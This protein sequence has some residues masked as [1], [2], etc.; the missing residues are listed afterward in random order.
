MIRQLE[1]SSPGLVKTKRALFFL[2]A[3]QLTNARLEAYAEHC[4][5]IVKPNTLRLFG[6]KGAKPY[7]NDPSG[8]S[9]RLVKNE[10]DQWNDTIGVWGTEVE[11]FLG[12]T[13]PGLKYTEEPMNANGAAHL[14]AIE[15]AHKSWTFV[16]GLH[17]QQ[18]PCLDQGVPFTVRRDKDRDGDAEP[19][20]P[21]DTGWFAIQIHAG[22]MGDKVGAWSAACQ[23]LWGGRGPGSPWDKFWSIIEASGQAS[24]EY[25][26]MDASKLAEFLKV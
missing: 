7:G 6:L 15:E 12:T 8:L 17:H 9:V 10:L 25:F 21:I 2:M 26:L 18:Y 23:V 3:F 13:D 4:G 11:I 1:T 16:K 20:E 5:C 24:F 22:G 14:L 19:V